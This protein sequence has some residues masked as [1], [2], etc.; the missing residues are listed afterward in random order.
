MKR[1][2]QIITTIY[3]T[4]LFFVPMP[5]SLHANEASS[6][7]IRPV[8]KTQCR[9]LLSN[10]EKGEITSMEF[11][12][13]LSE[14]PILAESW[15]TILLPESYT[16]PELFREDFV[17]SDTVALQVQRKGNNN[18]RIQTPIDISEILTISISHYAGIQN[19]LEEDTFVCTL[20]V[21][22]WEEFFE[23]DSIHLISP[24]N[25][26]FYEI[27]NKIKANQHGW[28]S[29]IPIL[30]LYS[31]K[32]TELYVA[33]N[34]DEFHKLENR[35]ITIPEGIHRCSFY[36][37]RPSGLKE[38]IQSVLWKV[39]PYPPSCIDVSPSHR[40]WINTQ[41][42]LVKFQITSISPAFLVISE[43]AYPVLN[44]EVEIPL[45]LNPGKNTVSYSIVNQAGHSISDELTLFVDITPP[46]I[47]LY[48]PS[49]EQIY[50]G[51][52]MIVNGK[53]EP[54]CLLSVNGIKLEMDAYGNFATE[55]PIAEGKN[56]VIVR[57][58]DRAGNV[59]IISRTFFHYAGTVFEIQLS[60]QKVFLNE[61]EISVDPFPFRDP[62]NG[63]IYAS[64]RLFTESLGYSLRWDSNLNAAILDKNG[65]LIYVRPND[66][67]IK[68]SQGDNVEEIDIYYAPTIVDGVIFV[69]IEFTKK[70]LGSEVKYDPKHESIFIIFCPERSE[71]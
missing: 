63:E 23:S 12:L 19:P 5:M 15:I 33:W 62:Q 9:V 48:S 65:V 52:H 53:T 42:P 51:Y 22:S 69:P 54:G 66:S 14:N 21:E 71:K 44:N 3:L 4:A 50:C 61:K 41:D 1:L 26:V 55:I 59:T 36:G 49:E 46:V 35:I 70:I 27:Q 10:Y 25:S 32:G 30:Q 37:L 28:M 20:L 68:V 34:E 11:R 39:D 16:I 17:F 38:E 2:F 24:Q 43:E 18:I 47:T 56:N 67:I 31:K 58:E 7:S 13:S 45:S 29:E 60:H 64:I 8:Q 40:T 6:G 57:S